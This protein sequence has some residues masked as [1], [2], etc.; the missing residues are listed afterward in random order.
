MS[1]VVISG[2]T[3]GSITLAAPAVSG[4]NTATLPAATGTVMVSGNQPLFYAYANTPQSITSSTLTRVTFGSK[5]YDT[6]TCFNNTGSTVT[7]NGLSVPAYAFC[8]NVAG[9]YQINFAVNSNSTVTKVA[10][11]IRLNGNDGLYGNDVAG[12]SQI[13]TLQANGILYL[14]GTSDYVQAYTAFIGSSP[15][16][17]GGTPAVPAASYTYFSA[18]LI[19]TA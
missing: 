15:Q 18:A 4:S 11:V 5:L 14:N 12:A 19:R 16:I 2:D 9:Y 8:P 17:Y 6:A 1:S 7:L 10:A 3:S 13:N